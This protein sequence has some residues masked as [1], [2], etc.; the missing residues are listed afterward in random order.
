MITNQLVSMETI[1]SKVSRDYKSGISRL[2]IL[3][4]TAEALSF[5]GT[6]SITEDAVAFLKVENYQCELPSNLHFIYTIGKFNGNYEKDFLELCPKDIQTEIQPDAPPEVKLQVS[7]G[8]VSMDNT[9]SANDPRNLS[10]DLGAVTLTEDGIALSE[11]ISFRQIPYFHLTFGVHSWTSSNYKRNNFTPIR[12][13]KHDFFLAEE[14][15]KMQMYKGVVDE[16]KV[17][18]FG[19]LRFSF[20]EGVIAIS[21]N[22]TAVDQKTGYPMVPNS[23]VHQTAITKYIAMKVA[24]REFFDNREGSSSKLQKFEQDWHWYCGSAQNLDMVP[25]GDEEFKEIADIWNTMLPRE[26]GYNE[27]FGYITL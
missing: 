20:K 2:D 26:G 1:F 15:M 14:K 21:Y 5:I 6:K 17:L 24:E 23:I 8:C 27:F 19:H 11:D 25:K 16:Y 4:W 18:P 9:L 3:D 12:L 13:A 10:V 7:C 22:R